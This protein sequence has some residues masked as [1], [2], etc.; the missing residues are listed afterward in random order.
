MMIVNKFSRRV[1]SLAAL[2]ATASLFALA[3]GQVA[4]APLD[5]SN[6]VSA[7]TGTSTFGNVLQTTTV[8]FHNV[9]TDG[10]STVDMRISATVK[11]NTGFGGTGQ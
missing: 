9:A 10:G 3:S 5:F 1:T 7:T 8:E 11:G 6:P 2:A 4:A